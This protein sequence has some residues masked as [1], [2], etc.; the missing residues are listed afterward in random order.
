MSIVSDNPSKIEAWVSKDGSLDLCPVIDVDEFLR[1]RVEKNEELDAQ[2][3][4][5]CEV[6]DLDFSY[7]SALQFAESLEGTGIYGD[8]G[9]IVVN[10]SNNEDLLSAILQY[11]YWQDERGVHVL[12]QKHGGGDS[13]GNYPPPDAYDCEDHDETAI[14]DNARGTIYC[15]DPECDKWWDTDDGYHWRCDSTD[16]QNLESYDASEERPEYHPKP[17]P[18]QRNLF[19]N[20]PDEEQKDSGIVWVDDDQQPHC[21]FCG[22]ILNKAPYP[23]G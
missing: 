1:D 6:L 12:L 18:L 22:G 16:Q 11:V 17:N 19:N 10:T 20:F 15:N 9:P 5:Y 14:F 2:Y 4:D 21:P 13:R 23:A 3:V 8:G 7:Q